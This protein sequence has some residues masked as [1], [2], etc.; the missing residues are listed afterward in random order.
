MQFHLF[1]VG[2]NKFDSFSVEPKGPTIADKGRADPE[3]HPS[4]HV[5]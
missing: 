5:F 3:K 2:L 4:L 1:H